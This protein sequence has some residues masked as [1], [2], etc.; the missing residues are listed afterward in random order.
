MS[1]Q[2]YIL[3]VQTLIFATTLIILIWQYK[4]LYEQTKY[5]AEQTRLQHQSNQMFIYQNMLENFNKITMRGMDDDAYPPVFGYHKGYLKEDYDEK[6]IR[7]VMYVQM[8]LVF[9]EMVYLL[10][11]KDMID[12]D[13]WKGWGVYTCETI[14]NPIFLEIWNELK[15]RDLYHKDFEA[16]LADCIRRREEILKKIRRENDHAPNQ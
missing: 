2:E 16:Y 15:G 11:K 12:S 13:I 7:Q 10:K 1:I 8:T 9:L 5:N 6:K 3:I 4:R 14:N